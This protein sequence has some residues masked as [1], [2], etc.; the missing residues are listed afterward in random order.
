MRSIIGKATATIVTA[1]ALVFGLSACNNNGGT[2]EETKEKISSAVTSTPEAGPGEALR[3]SVQETASSVVS[4]IT[5][6]WDQAKLNTFTAGFRTLYPNLASDRSDES[7][8]SIVKETC[9]AIESGASDQQQVAK[10]TQTATNHGTVPTEDQANR[11][12]QM[13]KPACP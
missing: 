7:I 8:E 10:V 9:T 5:G 6:A 2:S 13:V 4:G 11:I 12:L 3:S 1:S